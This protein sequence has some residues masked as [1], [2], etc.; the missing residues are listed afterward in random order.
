MDGS[1]L[2]AVAGFA[3]LLGAG[4]GLAG[5]AYVAGIWKDVTRPPRRGMGWAVGQ[6]LAASPG[7][8]GLAFEERTVETPDVRVPCWWI[9]GRG[10]ADK[11]VVVV[12]GHG[13]SRWDSLRRVPALADRFGLLVLPDLRGH[14]DAPGRSALARREHRDVC[15]VAAT[16]ERERP[17]ARITL[18]G[19]SLGAVAAIHAAAC[20]TRSPNPPERVIAWGP[21]DRV[22]TP[23]EA[24]LRLRGLPAGP[25]SGIVLAL[26]DRAEG[27]ETPTVA[28]AAMLGRTAL[29]IH[30]D[31]LDEVS[32][33]RDARAIAAACPGATLHLTRG[34]A[35]ADL[36]T[37]IGTWSSWH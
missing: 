7:D 1:T 17:D 19:H 8:L 11:A 16:V 4:A 37:E 25:F 24:R 9:T 2:G 3:A 6:G 14:G 26:L 15:F 33:A 20:L 36:G 18:A 27:P 10:P 30:A 31:E 32:P 29:E 12:H 23:F 28:S 5:G 34:V 35:H 13:R 22:R 21:Y